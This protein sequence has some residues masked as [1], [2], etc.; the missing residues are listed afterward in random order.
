MEFCKLQQQFGFNLFVHGI[1][2]IL[3]T[4]GIVESLLNLHHS[5]KVTSRQLMNRKN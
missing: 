2:E 4:S 1:T 5:N 3:T